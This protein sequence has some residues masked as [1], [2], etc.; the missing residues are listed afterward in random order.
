MN[1]AKASGIIASSTQQ[2]WYYCITTVAET[3]LQ[4]LKI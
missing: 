4:D 2:P 1:D 3:K